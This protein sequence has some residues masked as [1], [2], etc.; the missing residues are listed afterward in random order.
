MA[1]ALQLTGRPLFAIALAAASAALTLTGCRESPVPRPPKAGAAD[2]DPMEQARGA[3]H[4][5]EYGLAATRLR[6]VLTH[7]PVDLEAHYRLAVSASHLDQVDEATREF[8]WVVAHGQPDAPEV[9]IARGWLASR[10]SEASKADPPASVQAR[11]DGPTKSDLASV[12]GRAVGPDGAKR[13]LQLFLKG[14]PGT[15]VQDEY[16]VL[17]TDQQGGFRF[18]NVAPGDYMLTDTVAGP[19]TW[20]LRVSLGKGE[21]LTLDL[22]PANQA[23]VRN[24]FPERL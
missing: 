23:S 17:R 6:E 24:D 4:R 12:S 14:V 2:V 18:A 10:T 16:H 22:S 19:P 7:R 1:R 5:Q 11:P 15:S 8:E 21:R 3:M 13:R 20:R 9:K